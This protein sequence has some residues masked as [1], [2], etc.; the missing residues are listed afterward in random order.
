MRMEISK[1]QLQKTQFSL[2]RWFLEF[3]FSEKNRKMVSGAPES[4]NRK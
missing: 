1:R 4:T 3:L 2:E